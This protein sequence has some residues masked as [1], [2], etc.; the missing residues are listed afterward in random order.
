MRRDF[1]G[2]EPFGI[3][4]Q[5]DLI[6]SRQ[7]ALPFLDDLG[8]ERPVTVAGHLDLDLPGRLSQDRLRPGPVADVGG[9]PLLGSAVFLMTQVL[10]HLL[11][12]R[13]LQHRP[14]ELLEQPVRAGQGQTL[15]P[16]QPDQLP[17]CSLLRGGVRFLLR[18]HISQ[19][20]H[21]GTFPA[22]LQSARRAGNTVSET[23][24]GHQDPLLAGPAAVEAADLMAVG[25]Q[26]VAG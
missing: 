6:D 3:Q 1:P 17:S 26:A 19:C 16:G 23:V 10:S 4:R 21:H 13:R 18:G 8:F 7:P 2:G 5:H 24:P 14:G 11:V 25:D 22:D 15:L 12:Q 9:V 20:R